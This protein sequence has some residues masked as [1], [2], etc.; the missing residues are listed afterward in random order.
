[1]VVCTRL[2]VVN[3]PFRERQVLAK[4]FVLFLGESDVLMSITVCTARG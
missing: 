4:F 3:L 2:S 1:M